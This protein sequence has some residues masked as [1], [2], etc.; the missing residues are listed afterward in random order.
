MRNL[1]STS[2]PGV[3][4]NGVVRFLPTLGG[5]RHVANAINGRGVIVGSSED[6]NL[7]TYAVTWGAQIGKLA[8][9]TPPAG[10]HTH[11]E[12]NDNNNK[13]FVVGYSVGPDG[14]QHAMLWANGAVIDLN[15]V[16]HAQ[17]SIASG[18]NSSDQVV[19]S[20]TLPGKTSR[21]FLYEDGTVQWLGSLGR[22]WYRGQ[23]DQQ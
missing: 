2:M 21:G 11:S 22:W 12:A 17:Y 20:A 7:D 9:L 23:R 15:T 5:E 4:E 19:G 13:G 6:V 16:L 10:Q 8:S 18:I 3:W 14:F 1:L